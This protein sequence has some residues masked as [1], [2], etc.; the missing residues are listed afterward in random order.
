MAVRAFYWD[1]PIK[2]T[3]R[4]LSILPKKA[5]R[6]RAGNVGDIYN[7][8]LMRHLYGEEA[9]NISDAGKRLLLVGSIVHTVREGDIVVGAGTKGSRQP[10]PTS[11]P[12]RVLGVRGPLTAAKL[13]DS[14]YDLSELAFMLDPGLLI[15]DV[16][17]QTVDIEPVAGSCAF[18]PHYRERPFYKSTRKFDVLDVDSEPLE[19][20][21]KMAEYE[22]IYSSSL[23]GVI[24]AHAIG[25]PAVLVAPRTAEAE[26]KYQ[27]YYASVGLPWVTPDD[28]QTSLK[29]GT[30]AI[31][32]G[33]SGLKQT[34]VFPTL[35]ELRAAGIA[36]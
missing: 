9:Q 6:W 35:P 13:R 26:V 15:G 19:F 21:L 16:Y 23:H 1:N 28:L 10:A 4:R 29:R 14:G 8:D 33:L 7:R 3:D 36:V 34:A 22:T 32:D 18:I 31:P 25:R 27:D 24:F 11:A 20:I 17:P 5:S 30:P 2:N 12:V